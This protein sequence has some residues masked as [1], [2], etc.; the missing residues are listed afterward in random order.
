MVQLKQLSDLTVKD[1]VVLLRLDLN[2]PQEYGKITDNTRIIR[3]I[4]T[5][6]YLVSHNAKVVIISHFGRP[7]KIEL[8]LSLKS[9]VSEL[10]ALLNIKVK[11]CPESIGT[12]AKNAIMKMQAGEILLLENL[13]FNSGEE[14]NDTDFANQ[15]SSLGDVYVNDAFA[16]SHRKHA[17]ICGLPTKLPSAAG[18]SLLNELK[19]LSSTLSKVSKPFTAIIGGA[20][21]STKLDLLKSL[22]ARVDYLIIAGAMANMFLAIRNFN[23]GA[24]LYEPALANIAS[25]IFKKTTSTNCK[26]IL[27]FDVIVQNNNSIATIDLN[28]TVAIPS[29]AKIMDIGPKTIAQIINIIKISKTIVWNGPVGAFEQTPF[30][31]G[32]TYL[33]KAI[34]QETKTGNL[35]SV[36]GGGD[37]ISAIRKSG[38][39]DYFTYISTGGGA[40]LEWL[41]GKKLPGIEALKQELAIAKYM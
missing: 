8:R 15:L 25:V 35:C 39:I 36:A 24:S 9:I 18:F 27:P 29:N 2:L 31:Y 16:C 1:K 37:T 14:L 5:I 19:N 33:S 22:I 38:G 12:T 28:S 30:D 21:I 41:Q 23:I 17:S 26:I 34:T 4:P 20:K 7:K 32:S 13:R 3:I 6:K 10:E 40:F 11:F